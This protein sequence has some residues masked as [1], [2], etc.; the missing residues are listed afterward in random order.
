M[1][2][3]ILASAACVALVSHV[4]YT[5]S[6]KLM[7]DHPA[8][9]PSQPP[10]G[11]YRN[12]AHTFN[13]PAMVASGPVPDPNYYNE[14]AQ[15]SENSQFVPPTHSPPAGVVVYQNS[16]RQLMPTESAAVQRAEVAFAGGSGAGTFTVVSDGKRSIMVNTLTGDSWLLRIDEKGSH[17]EPI[18]MPNG[19][20]MF[21][22]ETNSSEQ[23]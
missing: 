15:S 11:Y 3:W 23:F 8:P 7:A 4:V 2:K 14:P 5:F 22:Q 19:A 6:D 18:K 20:D 9:T 21:G 16:A 17:W 1:R 13:A 10:Q 12:D